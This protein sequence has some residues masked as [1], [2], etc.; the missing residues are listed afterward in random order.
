M[1][2]SACSSDSTP[3]SMQ[4]PANYPWQNAAF[5][6][7]GSPLLI[8]YSIVA[9][10]LCPHAATF[11]LSF[12][13]AWPYRTVPPPQG[14]AKSRGRLFSCHLFV[15]RRIHQQVSSRGL[16][17]EGLL[18]GIWLTVHLYFGFG[19]L[20][21]HKIHM[22][23]CQSRKVHGPAFSQWQLEKKRIATSVFTVRPLKHMSVIHMPGM[24]L[25]LFWLLHLIYLITLISCLSLNTSTFSL[26]ISDMKFNLNC[27]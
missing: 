22:V 7:K 19:C 27:V 5:G 16:W 3:S 9:L 10:R 15:L 25:C 13:H 8:Y 18:F 12:Q 23:H 21:N 1:A 17:S 4:P 11:V 14:P 2:L 20:S 24:Y 26:C 6:G